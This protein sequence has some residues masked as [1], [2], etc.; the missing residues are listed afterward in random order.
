VKLVEAAWLPLVADRV[1][2]SDDD[3]L[4]GGEELGGLETYLR[5]EG[6]GK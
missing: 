6:T 1:G 3:A 4:A 2:V 5:L